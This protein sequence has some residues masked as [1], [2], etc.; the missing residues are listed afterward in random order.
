MKMV[1]L[2][3]GA[4]P[5]LQPSE[6][7]LWEQ[8]QA[9]E[10]PLINFIASLITSRRGLS[11]EL[12][13]YGDSPSA[14]VVNRAV[15]GVRV[16]EAMSGYDRVESRQLPLSEKPLTTAPAAARFAIFTATRQLV[17]INK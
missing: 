16:H 17:W 3:V 13:G 10:P 11:E 12:T 5:T 7:S 14:F 8:L 9:C 4:E 2:R 6:R 1:P 15:G